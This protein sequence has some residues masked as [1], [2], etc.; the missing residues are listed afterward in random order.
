MGDSGTVNQSAT[1][2]AIPGSVP[3][4][5]VG[6]GP[7]G[8]LQALLLSRLGVRSLIVERYT[9]RLG[10]PKAHVINPRSLEILRQYGLGEKRIHSLGT[11]RA[12][13]YW[14]KFHDQSVR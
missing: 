9:E 12:D 11:S 1:D 4:L 13:G 6:G 7:V 10:A 8:L 2:G 14:V 5:I 3:V